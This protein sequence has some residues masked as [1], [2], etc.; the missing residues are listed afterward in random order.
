MTNTVIQLKYSSITGNIP[1]SLANGE[2]AINYAD[3]KL[4][5][6]N[7]TGQIVGFQGAG[8]VYS[9]STINAN[10][11]LITALSNNSILNFQNGDNISITGDIINDIITISANLKPAFDVANAS[12]NVANAAYSNTNAT[13]ILAQAAFAAA[14]LSSTGSTGFFHSTIGT[15]PEEDYGSGE[16]YPSETTDA[17]GVSLGRVYDCMEPVG[18]IK[19]TD[20]GILT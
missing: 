18:S 15:F 17:F 16:S 8:N 2:L 11:S 1:A 9:F 7:T 20:L 14:N 10:N 6:K 12:Y 5:Y 4:Y 13:F 3:G 19:S